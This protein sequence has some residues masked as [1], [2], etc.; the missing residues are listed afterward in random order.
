MIAN[1]YNDES[2]ASRVL[3]LIARCA[4]RLMRCGGGPLTQ[5]PEHKRWR[6]TPEERARILELGRLGTLS[7]TQIAKHVGSTQAAVRKM[8]LKH[9][10]QPVR[11]RQFL[12]TRQ[13]Q[14]A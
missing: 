9:G 10:I 13:N 7:P 4:P 12:D 6:H 5:E 3:D 8:L 14:H 1:L 2:T 11:K